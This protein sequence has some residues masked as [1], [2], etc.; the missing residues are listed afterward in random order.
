MLICRRSHPVSLPD[1]LLCDRPPGQNQHQGGAYNRFNS[2]VPLSPGS[3]LGPYDVV[4]QIGA[5]GMGE[6]YRAVDPRLGRA[7]AIKVSTEPFSE[8]FERE[9][10]AVAALNHPNI[11]TVHDVGPNYLVMELIEGATLAETLRQG[12]VPVEEALRIGAEIAAALEAAHER[13]IIHRD[14]KPANIKIRAR[15]QRQGARLRPCEGRYRRVRQPR[16]ARRP[17]PPAP[18]RTAPFW[19]PQPT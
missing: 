2:T 9:A 8:R 16:I 12:P 3:T 17:S 15:R 11:C 1:A 5:G 10:R 13:G 18:P 6:V 7:V 19:E 4:S 14:L